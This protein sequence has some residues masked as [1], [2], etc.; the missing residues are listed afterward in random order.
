MFMG[1]LVCKPDDIRVFGRAIAR[2]HRPGRDDATPV[3]IELRPWKER[4][5]CYIR[6]RKAEFLDGTMTDGVSLNELMNELGSDTWETTRQKAALTGRKDIDPRKSLPQQTQLELT[7][8]AIG[9][10]NRKLEQ[11]FVQSGKI[12]AARLTELDWPQVDE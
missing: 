4:W 6:V 9:L 10:L 1:R 8:R 7:V 2:E 12:T 5:P 3:D 11:C